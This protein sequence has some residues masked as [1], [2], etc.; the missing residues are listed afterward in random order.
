MRMIFGLVLAV[1]VALAAAA[2]YVAQGYI[3]K[4]QQAL[5]QQQAIMQETG[6][7]VPVFVVNKPKNY[8]DILTRDDVQSI[9]WPKNARWLGSTALCAASDGTV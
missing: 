8:G 3:N 1:G 7:L 5:Q 9:L 4:N 2:V 6:G